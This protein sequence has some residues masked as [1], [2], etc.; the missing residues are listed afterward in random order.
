MKKK[1]TK[2]YF[3]LIFFATFCLS[4]AMFA[5]NLPFGVFAEDVS[6]SI[7]NYQS[8]YALDDTLDIVDQTITVAGQSLTMDKTVV[9]PSKKAVSADTI[10]LNEY[11]EYSVK[12][13]KII[14]GKYYLKEYSFKIDRTAYAVTDG[15]AEYTGVG[16]YSYIQDKSSEG[17][18]VTLDKK[19]TFTYNNYIN[20]DELD[21]NNLLFSLYVLPQVKGTRDFGILNI[22]IIDA[23]EPDNY[24]LLRAR[25]YKEI[26]SVNGE[27]FSSYLLASVPSAGQ[28]L[29]SKNGDKL[30][31]ED[32]GRYTCFSFSAEP[33]SAVGTVENDTLE[34]RY[35][36]K[37]KQLIVPHDLGWG[38]M[39]NVIADFDDPVYF[40]DNIWEGFSSNKVIFS[41]SIDGL[42]SDNGTFVINKVANQNLQDYVFSDLEPDINADF[43]EYTEESLPKAEVGK[44]YS[45]YK[46]YAEDDVDGVISTDAYV[47]YEKDGKILDVSV[48]NDAFVPYAA[49]EY[50]INYFVK[51]TTGQ[52]K[53][54]TVCVW[55]EEPQQLE[56]FVAER[57]DVYKLGYAYV[58]CDYTATNAYGNVNCCITVIDGNGIR[59]NWSEDFVFVSSGEHVIEYEF[60]D[61][62][63]RSAVKKFIIN[64]GASDA[65]V[66]DEDP[67]IPRYMLGSYFC[68]I[69]GQNSQYAYKIN[70]ITAKFYNADGSVQT[71]TADVYFDGEKA[72]DGVITPVAAIGNSPQ[73]KEIVFKVEFNGVEYTSQKYQT[74]VISAFREVEGKTQLNMSQYFA[75]EGF[76]NTLDYP[77][78][79]KKFLEY[80]AIEEDNYLEFVNPVSLDKASLSFNINPQKVDFDKIR[81]TFFDSE[82]FQKY[83]YADCFYD[84]EKQVS[85]MTV[86]DN[87]LQTVLSGSMIADNQNNI[88]VRYDYETLKIQGHPLKLTQ[89]ANGEAFD[90][91]PSGKVYIKVQIIGVTSGSAAIRIMKIDNQIF[92]SETVRDRVA[93][94]V[95]FE[96]SLNN[97]YIG[98]ER[99]TISKAIVSD[100]LSP[101]GSATFSVR[102][103]ESGEY[104]KDEDGKLLKD[105]SINKDYTLKPDIGTYEVVIKVTDGNVSDSYK[106]VFYV[107]DCISPVISI[108][109][110]VCGEVKAGT[111][112]KLPE[113]EITDNSSATEKCKKWIVVYY[114]NGR[115]EEIYSDEYVFWTTGKYTIGFFGTDEN[116]NTASLYYTVNVVKRGG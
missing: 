30:M 102:M 36:Q 24:I 22:R 38:A 10:V 107:I 25:A 41:V 71:K 51:T 27:G 60:T 66:W 104:V 115:V 53:T 5:V 81:V 23:F 50:K 4:V 59:L 98:G 58:P 103:R 31:V 101:Y 48:T 99:V 106:K 92:S 6:Y 95:M 90:C 114:D 82:Q 65:P 113:F 97:S 49:G 112:Y 40:G 8:S 35:D 77:E 13:S 14:N 72:E 12:Y 28:K 46:L 110:V 9:Y 39:S 3:A 91:F 2:R 88:E 67:I 74:T 11:G 116:G 45:L 52:L 37:Q 69:D 80:T 15:T 93:P 109:G 57:T 63:G 73:V 85:Y 16:E 111:T 21:E 64:I 84:R 47:Y 26:D 43:G 17:L 96:Q 29:T 89:Y 78:T 33:Y 76:V 68:E 83:V 87:Q 1:L 105:V 54:K 56:V 20:L 108:N 55:A 18:K 79:S 42:I 70:A 61:R 100:V 62:A 7:V 34:V 19:G 44:P 32:W 94:T 86:N 75:G